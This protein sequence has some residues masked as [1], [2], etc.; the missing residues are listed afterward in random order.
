VLIAL[1]AFATMRRRSARGDDPFDYD[2]DFDHEHAY[3][4]ASAPPAPERTS[5]QDYS[6]AMFGDNYAT[7]GLG[8]L[9]R[10]DADPESFWGAPVSRA[11]DHDSDYDG[12]DDRDYDDHDDRDDH[13][14]DEDD[15]F[16]Y[17]TADDD[18]GDAESPAITDDDE[19]PDSVD[20][21][22]TRIP[23]VTHI[24]TIRRDPMIDSGK[25]ARIE[26]DEP[27]PVRTAF[28]LPADDSGRPPQGYPVKAN[29]QSGRYWTPNSPQYGE[30]H[31][32][33]WFA[34][35]ELA[36]ANGFVGD[37]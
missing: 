29:T 31:A 20:T 28:R 12:H 24:P 16:A 3:R 34:T 30:A 1:V 5:A 17:E 35:A 22:P 26:D 8:A 4:A 23:P 11:D 19:D 6:A 33:I 37:D 18:R 9:G 27:A 10:R 25:H 13:D 15:D 14:Y 21:A 36:Q 32:E 2:D 7:E